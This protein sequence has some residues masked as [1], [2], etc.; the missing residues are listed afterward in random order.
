LPASVGCPGREEGIRRNWEAAGV[1]PTQLP[2]SFPS[3]QIPVQRFVSL[4]K[5]EPQ[6]GFPK[7]KLPLKYSE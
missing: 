3:P 6:S 1:H 5:L 2:Y 4:E 7:K